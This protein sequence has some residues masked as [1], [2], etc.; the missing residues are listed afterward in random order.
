MKFLTCLKFKPGLPPSNPKMLIAINEACKVWI[1]AKLED[2][3]LDCAY[4]VLPSTPNYYG[5][6]IL[7]AS[8]LEEVW[9][10]LST[11]PGL[12]ITDYE[13]YPLSNVYQAIDD[14]IAATQKMMGG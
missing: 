1:K 6:G 2:G 3:T 7:N 8:S 13:V 10:V 11:Y 12:P 4:N 9:R 5:T 14:V